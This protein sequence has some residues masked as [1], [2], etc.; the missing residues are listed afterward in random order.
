MA[1][2]V[3]SRSRRPLPHARLLLGL[4]LS[5]VGGCDDDASNSPQ[6]NDRGKANLCR[7]YNTCD[8]C[9]AGQQDRGYEKGEAETMCG[10]A[11]MGCFT[12]WEKPIRCGDKDMDPEASE[13]SDAGEAG[14]AE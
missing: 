2:I 8:E 3:M 13:A 10:A 14:D 1:T 12:T 4:C 7:D 9:I 5:L 11:V 6:I